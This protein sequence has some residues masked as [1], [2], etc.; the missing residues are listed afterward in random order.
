MKAKTPHQKSQKRRGRGPGSGRGKTSARGH[1][2]GGARS[3]WRERWGKEGGQTPFYMRFPKRGFNRAFKRLYSVI[4]LDT[5]A[6]LGEEKIDLELLKTLGWYKNSSDGVK[7]LGRGQ[8]KKALTVEA[9]AFSRTAKEQIEKAGGKAI[10]VSAKI[11][12]NQ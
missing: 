2:G 9:H 5:L 12:S 8:L 6:S 1:K 11:Q 4:N 3:G 7:V 10:L